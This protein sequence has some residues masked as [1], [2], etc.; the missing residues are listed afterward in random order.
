MKQFTFLCVI[1]LLYSLESV[2]ASSNSYKEQLL[3]TKMNNLVE[4]YNEQ[5]D[6]KVQ[7]NVLNEAVESIQELLKGY[8]GKAK[9]NMKELLDEN[10]QSH[11][12]YLLFQWCVAVKN[13]LPHTVTVIQTPNLSE[14]TRS[15]IR[16]RT[17]DLLL[18]GVNYSNDSII[19]IERAIQ[20]M[21]KL[22]VLLNVT[23]IQISQDFQSTGFYGIKRSELVNKISSLKEQSIF[24]AVAAAISL[25]T[26]VILGFVAGPV[27]IAIGLSVTLA[28][29]GIPL[30]VIYGHS[31]PKLEQQLTIIDEFYNKLQD[32]LI[33]AKR[34]CR[35]VDEALKTELKEINELASNIQTPQ[36]DDMMIPEFSSLFVD[37]FNTLSNS[38]K[39][40]VTSHRSTPSR[41]RRDAVAKKLSITPT[42]YRLEAGMVLNENYG[43][44]HEMVFANLKEFF[45]DPLISHA[46]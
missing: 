44:M 3:M 34:E 15:Y 17:K 24:S 18:R 10:S 29:A 36:P 31:I 37:S 22:G 33:R 5:L 46:L 25:L 23:E 41:R 1:L 43:V 39:R 7:W 21:S 42:N 38:C 14:N 27:G 9:D 30:G 35:K 8:Q 12:E 6:K 16:N 32:A 2:T 11:D 19:H 4:I 26:T 45:S 40:Y 20:H 13:D 28:T